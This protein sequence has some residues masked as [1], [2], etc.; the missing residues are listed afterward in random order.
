MTSG[1]SGTPLNDYT[2]KDR[3]VI[4]I[5]K[6]FYIVN[7]KDIV[8]IEDSGNNV[9]IFT[10]HK[11]KYIYRITLKS[12]LP[13]LDDSIFYQIH[14]SI[15]VNIDYVIKIGANDQG[16]FEVTLS[17]RERLKICETLKHILEKAN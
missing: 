10:Q 7:F 1:E 6:Q 8:Y 2:L 12:L 14:K 13:K 3:L 17:N 9:H 16:D 4:R 5:D 11:K 15:I